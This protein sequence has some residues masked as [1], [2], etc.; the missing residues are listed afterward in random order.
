MA[1]I[2]ETILSCPQIMDNGTWRIR[3]Y[4]EIYNVMK[5]SNIDLKQKHKRL[6]LLG[7]L[8]HMDRIPKKAL[9]GTAATTRLVGCLRT[10]WQDNKWKDIKNFEIHSS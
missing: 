1:I 8:P 7:H 2:K 6:K 5:K 4:Q 3:K 10:R 9:Y